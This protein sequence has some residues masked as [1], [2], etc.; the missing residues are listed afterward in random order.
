MAGTELESETRSCSVE[1]LIVIVCLQS[2]HELGPCLD[3]LR[4]GQP[5]PG[6]E[7][8]AV[9]SAIQTRQGYHSDG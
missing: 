7:F 9:N 8:I 5:G 6:V 3:M 1:C 2:P 4:E